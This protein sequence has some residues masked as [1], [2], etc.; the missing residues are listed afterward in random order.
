MYHGRPW[1]GQLWP[2]PPCIFTLKCG[3]MLATRGR[4]A[5]WLTSQRAFGAAMSVLCASCLPRLPAPGRQKSQ[6]RGYRYAP[7]FT[8]EVKI[9]VVISWQ[10][11]SSLPRTSASGQQPFLA[12][13]SMMAW[14][15]IALYRRPPLTSPSSYV[16]LIVS[17]SCGAQ[18]Y[19]GAVIVRAAASAVAVDIINKLDAHG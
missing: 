10:L 9:L 13:P 17:A 18:L 7:A 2:R 16:A 14:P 8:R 11:I 4:G 1:P 5:L 6:W 3:K 12:W 15:P 19:R